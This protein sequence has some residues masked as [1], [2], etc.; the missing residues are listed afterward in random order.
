MTLEHLVETY[1]YI[2]V[3]AGTF[4]EGEAVLIAGGIAAKLGYLQLPWV[5]LSAFV[6]TLIGDQL[7]FFMGRYRGDKFLRRYPSWRRRVA[8][9]AAALHRHRV[10]VMLGFRFFY[11]ARVVTSFVVG[12]SRIPVLEFMILNIIG[13]ALWAVAIGLLGY[14]FGHG[15]EIILGD[16]R[17]YE[18][19]IIGTIL[20]GGVVFW[21][22]SLLRVY[23]RWRS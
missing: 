9:A 20:T 17:R 10:L 2:A 21:L 23:R 4:L 16:L 12:I 1:G 6:G 13:A 5:I 11:G 8:K 7:I 22:I 18:L 15:L 14:A 19:A 3:L